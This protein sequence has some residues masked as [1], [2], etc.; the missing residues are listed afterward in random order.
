MLHHYGQEGRDLR[1]LS[2]NGILLD[3]E[4]FQQ[5][6]SNDFIDNFKSNINKFIEYLNQSNFEHRQNTI[7]SD[8]KSYAFATIDTSDPC[9]SIAL[10]LEV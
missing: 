9:I 3:I 1:K 8:C 10:T 5:M 2:T 7:V 4:M 6:T